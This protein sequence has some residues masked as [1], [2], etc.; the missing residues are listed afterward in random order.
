MNAVLDLPELHCR[1]LRSIPAWRESPK[2]RSHSALPS[3]RPVRRRPVRLRRW[4]NWQGLLVPVLDLV[5]E[6]HAYE[7]MGRTDNAAP[8]RAVLHAQGSIV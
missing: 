8:I 2:V 4:I 6:A 3:G 7:G 5:H 1:A